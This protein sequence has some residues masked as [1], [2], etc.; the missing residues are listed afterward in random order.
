MRRFSLA[1]FLLWGCG[2]DHPP[3]AASKDEVKTAQVTVWTDR[4]E[5]FLEHP[6]VVAGTPAPF[7]AHLTDLK[8]FEP[9]RE[10]R[11]VF[12]ASGDPDGSFDHVEES[13]QKAGIY[14]PSLTFPKP[15]Q[16]KL[17][18]RIPVEGGDARMDLPPFRVHASAAE[19]KIAA[20]KE[21]PEGIAFL[22]EQQWKLGTRS[23]PVGR[24]RLV[25]RL[26]LPGQVTARPGSRASLSAPLEG[27][28][29]APEGRALPG[30]GD[31]VEAN[32]VLALVQPPFSDLAAKI[33]EAAA[34]V[35]KTKLAADQAE[36]VYA[37]TK[38]LHEGQAKTDRDLQ[39]A[40]FAVRAAKSAREFA[41]TIQQAY[42]RAGAVFVTQEGKEL[43]ALE[44]RAPISG[45][46]VAVQASLGEHVGPEHPVLVILDPER[47]YVE[48]RIPESDV[49]RVS[50]S[51]AASYETPDARGKYVPLLDGGGRV[52]H[53]GLEVDAAS[54]TVALVYEVP[55]PARLLRIGMT[56]T[57][58]LETAR[59]EDAVA[60][61]PSALVDEEGRYVAFVQV[62]GETYEKRDLTLGVR[63]TDYVQIVKG[64][65]EGER[66]VTQGAYA[67]RLASVSTAIPAH[68]H[69][70]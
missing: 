18:L 30:L 38:K 22:K 2:H 13:P 50:A 35:A 33:V 45:T 16:W 15:G 21:A 26:R 17:S 48:A 44:L 31:R 4:F 36:Q 61:P 68:G 64:L 37:R 49:S 34:E 20:T 63:D 19:A 10:G 51:K 8:T 66:V 1:L 11:V 23:A 39:E 14:L 53:L 5:V 29:L 60:I 24:R 43:P 28:L 55:N 57:L 6:P 42:Q 62:A 47:V 27:R 7:A 54:R 3:A 9:R 70:H 56:L 58:Y 41:R 69:S 40:E 52:V 25:E 32:Q 67:I 12:S 46:V 65:S 59:A